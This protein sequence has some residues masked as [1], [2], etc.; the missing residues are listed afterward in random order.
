LRGTFETKHPEVAKLDAN[1][2][3]I[4]A[5]NF[6]KRFSAEQQIFKKVNTENVAATKVSYEISREIAAAGKSF[7][8]GDFIKKCMLIAVSGLCPGKRGTFE[9]VSLSRMTV[10]RREADISAN[11][12]D[13]LKQKASEFRFYSLAMDESTD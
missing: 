11:L 9:N 13:Q 6:V 3:Y 2:K 4:K 10:Q 8:E 7:T 5:A 1:E 12:S